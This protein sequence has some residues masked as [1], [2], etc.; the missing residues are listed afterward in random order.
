MSEFKTI[1]G[2]E[3]YE[4][5]RNGE[6]RNK[7]TGHI[8]TPYVHEKGYAYVYLHPQTRKPKNVKLHRLIALT[9]IPNPKNKFTVNHKD[10]DRLNNKAENLEWM[11]QTEN[12][13][14][15]IKKGT[16]NMVGE[17]HPGAKLTSVKV[18]QIRELASKGIKKRVL[19]EIYGVTCENINAIIKRRAWKHI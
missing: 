2:F 14:H 15:A 4:A 8:M 6:V 3:R 18:L 19:A 16:Y 13:R 5:S 9:F 12:I 17:N 1:P 7:K 10:S 11:T